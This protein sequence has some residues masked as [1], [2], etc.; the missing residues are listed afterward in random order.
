[1]VIP[2]PGLSSEEWRSGQVLKYGIAYGE[3]EIE[4]ARNTANQMISYMA[5][6][7]ERDAVSLLRFL[8]TLRLIFD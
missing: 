2:Q 5:T 6:E 8:N 3:E 1:M 7:K 4:W